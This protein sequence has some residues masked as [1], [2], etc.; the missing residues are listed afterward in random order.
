[1]GTVVIF[2]ASCY[3][4]YGA[5]WAAW[6]QLGQ[7]ARYV[8]ALYGDAPPEV[9]SDDQ[10]FVLDFSYPRDVL[11]ALLA[12]C[13][14]LRVL[15]HHKTAQADLEGL[16]FATFDLDKS[17]AMLAWEHWHPTAAPP[18]LIQYIQDRDLWRFKLDGSKAVTAWLRSYPMTFVGW[19]ALATQLE[20][21]RIEV[22]AEGEALLRFQ[23]QQVELMAGQARW[24]FLI[25][26]DI[27][28]M[29]PVVNASAFFS[30]VADR[31]LALHPQALFAAY[32]YDRADGRR[33]W[34]LRSRPG[35]DVSAIARQYGGGGH[36][37]AAGFTSLVPWPMLDMG[38]R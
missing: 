2:H 12:R 17:G 31:L 16:A 20:R 9:G 34:G 29:V 21:E 23:S 10:V 18:A 22:L 36:P 28:T 7:A 30:D 33:Q 5:A 25:S 37:T 19:N 14:S 26:G 15:D 6:K 13:A 38:K 4:G 3:D 32:Y 11:L 24:M 1:M 27:D 8:P 35:F